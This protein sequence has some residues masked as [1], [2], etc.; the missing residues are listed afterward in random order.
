MSRFTITYS[1]R[2]SIPGLVETPEAARKRRIHGLKWPVVVVRYYAADVSLAEVRS[3]LDPGSTL[4]RM[5]EWR[6]WDTPRDNELAPDPGEI[7]PSFQ[8]EVY[9]LGE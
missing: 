6:D 9:L 1:S 2:D 8:T 4:G 5:I 3:A 7:R